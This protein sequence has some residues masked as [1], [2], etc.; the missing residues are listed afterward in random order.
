MS[1]SVCKECSRTS[2]LKTR[3]SN[4]RSARSPCRL[5]SIAQVRQL[6]RRAF[7]RASEID[8]PTLVIQGSKDKVVRP[9]CT[10][11]LLN[12]FPIRVQ[13]QDVNAAHDLVNPVSSAWNEVK[14][15]LLIFAESVR[16]V[17]PARMAPLSRIV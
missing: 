10:A 3:R 16:Q 7:E 8:V 15:T 11:R 13:Y 5:S 6:G 12:R 4:R 17:T 9:E 2:T 14:E 1:A